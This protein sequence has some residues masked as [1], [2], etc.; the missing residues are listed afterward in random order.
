MAKNEALDHPPSANRSLH[1]MTTCDDDSGHAHRDGERQREK[2]RE[3][4]V[5][6][7]VIMAT[8]QIELRLLYD[9][10]ITD[11]GMTSYARLMAN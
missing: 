10:T 7:R 9:S 11:H 3:R 2:E 5:T 6:S 1:G 8:D 4:R